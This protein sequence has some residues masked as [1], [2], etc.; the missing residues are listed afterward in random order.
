MHGV[1]WKTVI[2]KEFFPKIEGSHSIGQHELGFIHEGSFYVAGGPRAL[3]TFLVA[4]L[5]LRCPGDPTF[6]ACCNPSTA[7]DCFA[8]ELLLEA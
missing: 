4:F 3:S 7:P 5:A 8:K 2:I 6:A 1:H